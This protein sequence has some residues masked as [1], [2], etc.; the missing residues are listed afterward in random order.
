MIRWQRW[1]AYSLA[2][3]LG[4]AVGIGIAHAAGANGSYAAA[5]VFRVSADGRTLTTDILSVDRFDVRQDAHAVRIGEFDRPGL[6]CMFAGSC[7]SRT[8]TVTL[9]R[10]LG[11]RPLVI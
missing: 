3:A 6:H 4:V 8:V 2:A 10:P 7:G 1:V 11:D 5:G 9:E